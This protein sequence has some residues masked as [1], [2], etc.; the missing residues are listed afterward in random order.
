MYVQIPTDR[1]DYSL[2]SYETFST[3]DLECPEID[4]L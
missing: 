2:F 4:S 3:D 1:E